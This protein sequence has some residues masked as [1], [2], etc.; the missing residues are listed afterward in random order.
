LSEVQGPSISRQDAWLALLPELALATSYRVSGLVLR[1]ILPIPARSGGGRLNERTAAVQPRRR[2]RVK[3]PL[4]GPSLMRLRFGR[5]EGKR[6]CDP[7]RAIQQS[8][9]D[10][11][12][13][14]FRTNE[15][16]KK[17]AVIGAN[18]LGN[19]TVEQLVHAQDRLAVLLRFEGPGCAFH[20]GRS[21]DRTAARRCW[22]KSPPAS[23]AC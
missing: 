9:V 20:R 10:A 7:N 12:A 22:R 17:S 11:A 8:T 14:S 1:R 15:R 5:D 21:A 19:E 2:E 18:F 13:S 3:V 23:A 4:S 16:R 6:I